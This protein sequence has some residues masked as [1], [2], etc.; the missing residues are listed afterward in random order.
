MG[1]G[2]AVSVTSNGALGVGGAGA[3]GV[4]AQSIGGGGGV[5]QSVGATTGSVSLRLGAAN[6]AGGNG[7]AVSVTNQGAITTSAAGAHAIVA[8]SIG[9]GGGFFSAASQS[10]ALLPVAIS[11]AAGGIGGSGGSISVVNAGTINTSGDGASGII[12]QSIG[13]GGGLVSGGR[14]ATTLP[15]SGPFAGSLGGTGNAA[16][17]NINSS[18]R[19]LV[20]GASATGIFSQSAAGTGSG[21]AVNVSVS[22]DVLA[23]GMD[24]TGILARS[25]GGAGGANIAVDVG[26][27]AVVAGGSGLGA[28]VAF[29]STAST[30]LV[31]A[32]TITT[33][34]GVDGFAVRGDAGDE[35]ISNYGKIFGSV[36]LAGG[37]NAFDNKAGAMLLSGATV[38][39]GAG[40]VLINQ[41]LLSPGDYHRVLT[42]NLTG[43]LV[44]TAAGTYGVDVDM[45]ALTADRLAITG[46]AT[47]AGVIAVNVANPLSTVQGARPGTRDIVFLRA[48]GGASVPGLTLVAPDTV[49]AHYALHYPNAN[50]IALRYVVDYAPTGLAS[51]NQRALANTINAIQNAQSSPRFGPL[52]TALFFQ[53]SASALG[54]IYDSL[55]GSATTGSQQ[56]GFVAG[57]RFLSATS[58]QAAFWLSNDRNDT[59]GYTVTTSTVT[60]TTAQFGGYSGLGGP[61]DQVLTSTQAA[62]APPS[63]VNRWRFWA[64]GFAGSSNLSG[65]SFAGSVGAN[66]RGGGISAGVDVQV[67]RDLLVGFAS[68]G[69]TYG[70]SSPERATSGTS[71]G[72]HVSAYGAWRAGQSYISGVVAFSVA[73]NETS[74]FAY[75]PGVAIAM[76]SGTAAI[77]G[78]AENLKGS[79]VS[80]T[81]SGELEA[82]Y[83]MNLGPIEFTPFASLQ[84]A[85][86]Y[87]SSYGETVVN[88][89]PSQLGLRYAGNSINSLPTSLGAQLRFQTDLGVDNQLSLWARAA[90][91]REWLT[92]RSLEASFLTAPGF[93][94][95]MT[96]AKPETDA[97]RASLGARLTLDKNISINAG[98]EGDFTRS[99]SGYTGMLGLRVQW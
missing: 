40:N 16:A 93:N 42:T 14:F 62:T 48:E 21:G 32:G 61:V 89:M 41:G 20:N 24:S 95:A 84:F 46:T 60:T 67:S 74:R 75:V 68:G 52:A 30:T 37:T 96:G 19:V 26:A 73:D 77:P 5:I 45:K 86:Q 10:G 99:G 81:F 90:W 72:A 31:N 76:A 63:P 97:L 22:A 47:V 27:N 1:A 51:G 53:P 65:N 88:G 78:F 91:R 55:S 12:A 80:R 50:E 9:G 98:L 29:A 58:G 44:Q 33:S 36:D 43:N 7:A 83:R 34:I 71:E 82:G 87:T 18:G 94:F 49:V 57:D 15:A 56:I 4:L 6:G 3:V 25:T 70:F 59:T 39:L 38:H 8:Q 28:G 2:A 69:S 79:F 23:T 13:G 85:S 64:T 54:A 11:A 17:V 35:R 66:Q 92:D